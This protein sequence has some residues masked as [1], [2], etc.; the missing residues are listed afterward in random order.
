MNVSN[1]SKKMLVI[2]FLVV[3]LCSAL[4]FVKQEMYAIFISIFCMCFKLKVL[5]DKFCDGSYKILVVPLIYCIF[6]IIIGLMYSV[7]V[8]FLD[9]VKTNVSAFEAFYFC[10]ITLT[11]VGYGE[12]SPL[13]FAGQALSISMALVGRVHMIMFISLLISRLR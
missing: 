13:N 12:L 4:Y 8:L 11:T 7:P 10:I 3:M 1:T 2:W 9:T 6:L 5:D